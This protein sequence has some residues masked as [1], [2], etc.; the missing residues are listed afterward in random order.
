VREFHTFWVNSFREEN[1]GHYFLIN[2]RVCVC[3][4]VYIYIYIYLLGQRRLILSHMYAYDGEFIT[5]YFSP[6]RKRDKIPLKCHFS[7]VL[8]R[9]IGHWNPAMGDGDFLRR[10]GALFCIVTAERSR[11]PQWLMMKP[12]SETTECYCVLFCGLSPE[13]NAVVD[14]EFP[15]RR[16]YTVYCVWWRQVKSRCSS[17]LYCVLDKLIGRDWLICTCR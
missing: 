17:Q 5:H 8:A 2:P 13:T 12:V 6:S 14:A 16:S 11:K 1:V 3:V 4:C 7:S 9:L 10:T 15:K